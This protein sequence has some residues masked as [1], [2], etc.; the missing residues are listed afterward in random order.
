MRGEADLQ[1]GHGTEH[2][3]LRVCVELVLLKQSSARRWREI[4]EPL[5]P[6]SET[7]QLVGHDGSLDVRAHSNSL[8]KGFSPS[9]NRE[10]SL[11]WLTSTRLRASLGG[12]LRSCAAIVPQS[13]GARVPRDNKEE[14]IEKISWRA[15]RKSKE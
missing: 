5:A 7:G 14:L 11:V 4:K 15:N 1:E 12:V 9:T 10:E 2:V 13:T 3:N 8:V 6:R